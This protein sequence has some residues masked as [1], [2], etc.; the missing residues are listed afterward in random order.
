MPGYD[1]YSNHRPCSVGTVGRSDV[2]YNP[3]Y[4]RTLYIPRGWED[5]VHPVMYH[6]I[7]LPAFRGF[8]SF[9]FLPDFRAKGATPVKVKV[10]SS[11]SSQN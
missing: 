3:M 6:V 5:G 11:A 10:A 8:F 4:S 7:V 2:P 1:T 9:L